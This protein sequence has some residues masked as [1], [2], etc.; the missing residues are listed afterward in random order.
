MRKKY[1]DLYLQEQALRQAYE[2]IDPLII[3]KYNKRKNFLTN[4]ARDFE[5]ALMIGDITSDVADILDRKSLLSD[6]PDHGHNHLG[7]QDNV[8]SET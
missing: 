6:L 7:G 2:S 3:E 4:M 1:K 8:L 5:G